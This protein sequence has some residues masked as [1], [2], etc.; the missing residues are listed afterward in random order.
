MKE[1]SIFDQGNFVLDNFA[2]NWNNF[3]LLSNTN[4]EKSY[5]TFLEKFEFLVD[6]YAHLKK[7]SKNKLK[8]SPG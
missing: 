5:K 4:T 2:V 8:I 7:N 6:T 3:L 1:W